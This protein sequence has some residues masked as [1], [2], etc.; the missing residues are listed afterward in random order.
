M[1]LVTSLG[2]LLNQALSKLRLALPA[3][4]ADRFAARMGRLLRSPAVR[5]AHITSE[6]TQALVQLARDQGAEVPESAVAELQAM[7]RAVAAL[8]HRI[9]RMFHERAAHALRM[10]LRGDPAGAE[11]FARGRGL[12]RFAP[13]LL[14]MGLWVKRVLDHGLA[15]FGPLLNGL[16]QAEARALA[17]APTRV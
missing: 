14:N 12:A 2:A 8:E 1:V 10:V 13:R 3:E 7:V 15:V 5:L 11:A 9:F 6:A 17:A 4:Q 16:L